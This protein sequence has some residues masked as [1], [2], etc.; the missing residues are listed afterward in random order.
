MATANG[1]L[2][3]GHSS[4]GGSSWFGHIQKVVAYPQAMTTDQIEFLTK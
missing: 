1:V 4:Q 3:L 2:H